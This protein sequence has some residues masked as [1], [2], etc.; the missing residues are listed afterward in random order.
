MA[1]THYIDGLKRDAKKLLKELR[2][3]DSVA[4]NRFDTPKIKSVFKTS[5]GDRIAAQAKLKHAQL[6]IANEEGFDTWEEMTRSE[7]QSKPVVHDNKKVLLDQ[8]LAESRKFAENILR[9]P[10]LDSIPEL[11]ASAQSFLNSSGRSFDDKKHV[12]EFI[13]AL[14][15]FRENLMAVPLEHLVHIVMMNDNH[16]FLATV[17]GFT[18][19][20]EFL[21]DLVYEAFAVYECTTCRGFFKQ[22]GGEPAD[23]LCNERNFRKI[24]INTDNMDSV[25]HKVSANHIYLSEL[26]D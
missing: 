21:S 17:A 5:A 14:K 15:Q 3:G 8:V 26:D 9:D 12:H 7:P 10:D 6:V 22:S 1:T 18:E 16:G 2:A 20:A 19:K 25:M 13:Q 4:C 23:C 11:G 24:D